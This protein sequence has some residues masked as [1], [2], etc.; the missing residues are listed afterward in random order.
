MTR[1]IPRTIALAFATLALFAT[2]ALMQGCDDKAGAEI[3]QVTMAGER[4]YL[5]IAA[6][7][8]SR[9]LGL[10]HRTE[11]APDGGMIFVFPPRQVTVQSFWM[12]NCLVDM[13]ILYLDGSGKVLTTYTML[14]QPLKGQAGNPNETDEDY[15]RRIRSAA[16]Y[17]SRF[18]SPIVIEVKAGTVDR[19]GIKPGDQIHFDLAALKAKAR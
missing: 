15:E 12:K 16:T 11:I 13:D 2:A 10:M 7:P 4:F 19:L 9:Q 17:S 3:F 14:A 1:T 5:E 18:P 6:D 8:D